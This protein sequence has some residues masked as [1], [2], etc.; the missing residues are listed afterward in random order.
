[1]STTL[2]SRPRGRHTKPTRIDG[3]RHIT[4]IEYLMRLLQNVC[5]FAHAKKL[6]PP[7]VGS[8]IP[9]WYKSTAPFGE[10]MP[11]FS[12]IRTNSANEPAGI[13]W[14]IRWS[15]LII[16]TKRSYTRVKA[17][18]VL[19]VV[20]HTLACLTRMWRSYFAVAYPSS[21]MCDIINLGRYAFSTHCLVYQSGWDALNRR[22][23]KLVKFRAE[24]H[25]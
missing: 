1:L 9:P 23:G 14:M 2:F 11:N 16:E 5:Y 8:A 6:T 3:Y 13:S 7:F 20:T 4:V 17:E 25:A 12:A 18:T 21:W 15:P 22:R 24:D 10:G 19:L